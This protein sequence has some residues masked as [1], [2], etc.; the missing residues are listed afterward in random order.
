ME[1]LRNEFNSEIENL[2]GSKSEIKGRIM[3]TDGEKKVLENTSGD[4][5]NKVLDP[6]IYLKID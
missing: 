5:Q 3:K 1:L 4:Q 6:H 2:K